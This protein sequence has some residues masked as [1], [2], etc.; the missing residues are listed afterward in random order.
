MSAHTK[1]PWRVR[2]SPGLPCFIEAPKENQMAYALE[3]MGDDYTGYGEEQRREADAARIVAAVNGCAG[4]NPTAYKQVVEAI[5]YFLRHGVNAQ[6]QP[7]A[8]A[9]VKFEHALSASG[10]TNQQ[11]TLTAATEQP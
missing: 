8:E 7:T 10:W 6:G 9:V 3:I 4:L 2:T 11:Q 5:A 1:E